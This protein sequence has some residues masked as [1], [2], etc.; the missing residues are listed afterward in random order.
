M[1]KLL[2]IHLHHQTKIE[3][4]AESSNNI[5]M[6]DKSVRHV[7]V[8]REKKLAKELKNQAK[9]SFKKL[10]ILLMSQEIHKITI[11]DILKFLLSIHKMMFQNLSSKLHKNIDDNKIIQISLTAIDNDEKSSELSIL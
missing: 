6:T 8:S 10:L 7:S 4:D 1:I 9:K 11:Q 2:R 5:T 3:N